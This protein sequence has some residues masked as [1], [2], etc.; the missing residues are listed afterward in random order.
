MEF[1]QY[2]SA[3]FAQQGN[4][5][6]FTLDQKIRSEINS[7]I[8]EYSLIGTLGTNLSLGSVS[9]ASAVFVKNIGQSWNEKKAPGPGTFEQGKYA[10]VSFN[11]NVPLYQSLAFTHADNLLGFPQ[12]ASTK[13]AKASADFNDGFEAD[14][15]KKIEE[16][17]KQQLADKKVVK[18]LLSP[19]L[20]DRDV[21]HEIIALGTAL[22]KHIDAKD[23]INGIKKSD[24]IIHVK[25]EVLDRLSESALLGNYAE[26]MFVGGQYSI[27]TVGGYKV[28]ANKY[29]TDVDAIAC[30]NFSAASMVN[31]NAANYERLAPTNDYGIY[32]EA[33]GLFGIAYPTCFRYIAN[34]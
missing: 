8:V 31:V 32:Y 2:L 24:I 4:N 22:T 18:D 17:L 20:S 33:M 23:G 15:W 10:K 13:I 16:H 30:T 6:Q 5:E 28:I 26:Q 7:Y 14:C 21:R 12:A 11:W 19:T 1:K 3:L 29:L 34:A 9:E 27:A 25:P